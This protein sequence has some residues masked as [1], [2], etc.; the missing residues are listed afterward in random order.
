MNPNSYKKIPSTKQNK[1]KKPQKTKI[2]QNQSKTN[3]KKL[4][5]T[6]TKKT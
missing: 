6:L 5:K 1:H 2:Q 3:L 4:T